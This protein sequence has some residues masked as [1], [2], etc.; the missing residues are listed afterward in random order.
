MI[1]WG[2]NSAA[3]HP[4]ALMEMAHVNLRG[5]GLCR[6]LSGAVRR[7]QYTC[8]DLGGL[9]QISQDHAIAAKLRTT[10]WQVASVNLRD[11][12]SLVKWGR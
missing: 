5:L 1:S 4:H 8:R 2:H 7:G 11:V 9:H 10:Q 6:A 3:R 12:L